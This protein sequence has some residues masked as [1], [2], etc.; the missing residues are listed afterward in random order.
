MESPAVTFIIAHHNYQ[1]YLG[2]AI[3]SA[4]NQTYKNIHVCVIDDCSNDQKSVKDIIENKCGAFT[5]QDITKNTTYRNEKVTYIQLVKPFGSFKQA[6]VRN[7]GIETC[8]NHTDIFAILDSDDENYPTKIEKCV[9]I[10][11]KYPEICAV[12]TDT[13]ILNGDR[14][15]REYRE[16]Y[17]IRRLNQECIIHS[18]CVI[19]KSALNKIRENGQIFDV[20]LPPCEDYD[21]W[22]RLSEK[23]LFYH[24]PEPLVLVRVHPQNSTNTST[25]EHRMTK[26]R[27]IFEK[28]QIRLS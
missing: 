14:L 2:S 18:G 26:L 23:F 10:L 12:Y 17:D 16:P 22:I 13:N 19:K 8:W 25:H 24:I 15:V 1:Q 20:D 5:S 27:R 11:V 7:Q 28:K 3:D 6:F 4:L 21:L 9:N